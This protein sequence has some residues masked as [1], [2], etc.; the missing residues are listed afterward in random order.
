MGYATK[1]DLITRYGAEEIEQLSDR[2]GE[3]GEIDE[4]VVAAAL[5]R[6][7]AEINGRLAAAYPVPLIDV[8]PII[9][10]FAC[11]IA[12]YRLHVH[13]APEHVRK[14]YEGATEYLDRVA[15]GKAR[16]GVDSEGDAQVRET[17][18]HA[19]PAADRVFSL[20][21]GALRA[22]GS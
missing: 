3:G 21:G 8:A 12:R 16:L 2:T 15:Q 20:G 19:A 13:A 18:V 4:E 5:E 11:Q 10:E 22:Y 14:D 1:A 9:V 17:T 6:A 7:D